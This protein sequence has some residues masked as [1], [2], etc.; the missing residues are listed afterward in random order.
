MGYV[1]LLEWN[2]V[3]KERMQIWDVGMEEGKESM[4]WCYNTVW[5][6]FSYLYEVP[7]FMLFLACL[8]YHCHLPCF[9][10]WRVQSCV[11]QLCTVQCT[12]IWTGLTVLW[13]GFCLSGPISLCLDSF[14]C[15]YVFCASLYIACFST[16]TWWGGH[17]RIEA[18]SLGLLLPSVLW[19]CWLGHVTHKNPSPI[20]PIMC[21]VGR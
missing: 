21:L 5:A 3:L 1:M 15:M 7:P 14:L 17:G 16:V 8:C 11:Q 10:V 4:W 20:W 18:W 19:R 2:P 6:Y 13:I 12:H 9:F